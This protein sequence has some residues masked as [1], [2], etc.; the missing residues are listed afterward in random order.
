MPTRITV[1]RSPTHGKERDEADAEKVTPII[2][3]S[4]EIPNPTSNESSENDD[5]AALTSDS[6]TEEEKIK[7]GAP[8]QD[9]TA[10][11]SA[12][13]AEAPTPGTTDTA[14]KTPPSTP[15]T[16]GIDETVTK[17]PEIE[18]EKK[19]TTPAE[20]EE[21]EENGENIGAYKKV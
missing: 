3:S 16:S 19:E 5:G 14:P 11:T 2:C 8:E 10:P 6:A 21:K 9:S 17:E 12:S 20:D 1:T 15:P 7:D 13:A 18:E 4:E